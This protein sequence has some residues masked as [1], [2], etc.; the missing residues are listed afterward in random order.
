MS[1]FR[2]MFGGKK[3]A[4]VPSMAKEIQKLRETEDMLKKKREFL[5]RK[6]DKE[7]LI[8]KT[9]AA[10]YKRGI[11]F[12]FFFTSRIRLLQFNCHCV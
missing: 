12:C 2:K 8:A 3:E 9:N 1:F 5:E 10:K 6:M 11:V 7:M 4:A